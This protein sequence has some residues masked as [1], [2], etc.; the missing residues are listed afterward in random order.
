LRRPVRAQRVT[1]DTETPKRRATS[2]R[3]RNAGPDAAGGGEA[4]FFCVLIALL[5]ED[6]PAESGDI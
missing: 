6:L 5:P 4:E 3:E 2:P 1:V